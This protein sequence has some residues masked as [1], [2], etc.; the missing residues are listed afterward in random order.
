M[1]DK[2]NRFIDN[3]NGQ[4]VEVSYRDAIY[5]CLDL[6]YNWVFVLDFPKAT[7]Q[8]QY[9][10]EVFTQASDFTREY[11]DIIPNRT[12]TIP[13][14]GD[15]VVWNKTSSNIAGHIAIVIEATQTKMKVFEQNSPLGTN[16]HISDK[17]YTNCLGFLRPKFKAVG[18]VPQYLSTLLQEAGLKIDEEAS[19]RAFWE[20][21]KKYDEDTKALR[22]Q[23]VTANESLS[24]KSTELSNEIAKVDSLQATVDE[25]TEKLNKKGSELD[26]ITSEK[27]RLEIQN[28]DLI[29]KLDEAEA[30]ID[31][32][33]EGY[34]LK[35]YSWITRF[36]SLFGL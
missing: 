18:G 14:E 29:K 3:L 5:Q 34:P 35:T 6:V 32:L 22:T 13:Q 36:K 24:N 30:K 8:H 16:A 10:Y 27:I 2:L 4:F 12:E 15:I 25:L 31:E 23:L 19:I 11:F 7:I 9:A 21:A 33:Q 28:E 1:R 26:S 20:K 17:T